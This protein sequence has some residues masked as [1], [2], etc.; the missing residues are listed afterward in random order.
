[1]N[2]EGEVGQRS[3]S[4]SWRFVIGI[5]AAVLGAIGL[6]GLIGSVVEGAISQDFFVVC[7][8]VAPLF[9]LAVLVDIG[10]VMAPVTRRAY[11]EDPDDQ[12]GRFAALSETTKTFVRVDLGMLVISE[13][14]AL[15]AVGGRHAS[16]YLVVG[17]VLPWAVQLV[18]LAATTY[19]RAGIREVAKP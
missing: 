17:S 7:G 3:V 1:V 4:R 14:A 12:S 19:H 15:L 2:L 13:T 8:T 16:P 6:V 5:Y 10:V 18:V 9:G 11:D